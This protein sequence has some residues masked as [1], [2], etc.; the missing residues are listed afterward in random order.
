MVKRCFLPLLLLFTLTACSQ[1]PAMPEPAADPAPPTESQEPED[2]L[3]VPPSLLQLREDMAG[4]RGAIAYLGTL[5]SPD[6]LPER[7]VTSGYFE[8]YPF[9]ASA[10][11]I[12]YE[13]SHAYCFVPKDPADSLTVRSLTDGQVLYEGAGEPIL[14][15]CN[16]SD[17]TPNTEL[18][19]TSPDGVSTTFSPALGMCDGT[20]AVPGDGT[21]YDFSRYESRAPETA[22][23]VSFLGTWSTQ[24]VFEDQ[25][26]LCKLTFQPD[27]T[28][29]YLCG[30]VD[31]DVLDLL[32]GT[33]Y[34][35][36]DNAK[37][38]PGAVLFELSFTSD[39]TPFW[40]VFTIEPSDD[41]GITV[42]HVSGDPLI[43]GFNG[44]AL[45]FTPEE[46]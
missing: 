5:E 20:V 24:A 12:S 35:V 44:A 17:V 8:E 25:P 46:A 23:Q 26:I 19:L 37:Y 29:E 13:G 42:T 38:P 41:G 39:G 21:V 4:A 43:Y 7:M 9:L 31:T 27:G 18:S 10:P 14:L 28:M 16:V 33:F 36:D 6:G 32:R 30:Y 15:I 3:S 45:T 40:G 1:A 2:T 34:V 22:P 11:I